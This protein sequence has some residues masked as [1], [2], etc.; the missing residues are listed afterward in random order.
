[1]LAFSVANP[2]YFPAIGEPQPDSFTLECINDA[3][4]DALHAAAA[5]AVEEAVLNALVAARSVPTVKPAGRVLEAID[6][7][8]L[9][10]VLRRYGRL[11]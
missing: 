9:K 8:Q 3:H 1:M 11:S 5:Q 7:E 2:L 6:H 4:I 10:D